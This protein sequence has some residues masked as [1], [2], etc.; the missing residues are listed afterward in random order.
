VTVDDRLSLD[1]S[2]IVGIVVVCQCGTQMVHEPLT[3]EPNARACPGCG[4]P[5]WVGNTSKELQALQAFAENFKDLIRSNGALAARFRLRLQIVRP[6]S[7]APT[8]P[9][10]PLQ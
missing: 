4:Q 6:G 9:Q 7:V 1:L 8:K 5:A 2:D 3:W 10:K